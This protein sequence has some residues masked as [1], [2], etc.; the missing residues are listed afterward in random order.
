MF[1]QKKC[2]SREKRAEEVVLRLAAIVES[3]DDAI[4]SKT[5]DG[6]ITSWNGGAERLYGYKAEEVI[7]QP[8]STLLPPELLDDLPDILLTLT[9]FRLSSP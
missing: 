3:S 9:L 2:Q 7:G 4:I 6:A 5:L 1:S 8:I